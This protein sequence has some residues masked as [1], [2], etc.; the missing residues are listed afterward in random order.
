MARKRLAIPSVDEAKM[1]TNVSNE[2]IF[3]YEKLFSAVATATLSNGKDNPLWSDPVE[4][5]AMRELGFTA[6]YAAGPS[7]TINER[8]SKRHPVSDLNIPRDPVAIMQT[9]LR[10]CYDNP[11]VAKALRVKT[12][13]VI[14]NFSH[15]TNNQT[16]KDFYDKE[17][18]RLDLFTRSREIC[19]MA[20]GVG[21]VPIYWGGEETGRI[22]FVEILDPRLVKIQRVM[23]KY[24][25]YLK[26]DQ[27][28]IDAAR[29]PQGKINIENK[30]RWESMP[31]YW[32]TAILEHI[33][34]GRAGQSYIELKDGSYTVLQNRYCPVNRIANSIDGIPLQP[35]FD[36]LQRYRLLA[37]G[38][39]A[40]AWNVKNMITLI[41]EGDPKLDV[42]S[43]A[44]ADNS[45]LAALQAKF[46]QPDYQLTVYCDPTTEIRYVVPPIEVF[47]PKKYQQVEKE[48]KELLNLPAFMWMDSQSGSYSA[49]SAEL[50]LLREEVDAM[51]MTLRVQFYMPLYSRLRQAAS[52][53]GFAEKAIELPSF[54][55]NSLRD[56]QI[57]LPALGDLYTRGG[58]SLSSYCEAHGL[59]FDYEMKKLEE[60]H[61]QLKSNVSQ[62]INPTI[63]QPLHEPNQGNTDPNR[64]KGGNSGSKSPSPRSPRSKGE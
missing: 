53:P 9:A 38:D 7:V 43:Y 45:R 50:K 61:K 21:I 18:F 55:N 52:K 36:A 15:K 6:P 39:F 49:A 2:E 13:F 51:R 25:L 5:A 63:A 46:Q 28:M 29:D 31:K 20:F 4:L 17:A 59:D 23:G 33:N 19:W 35:A 8:F 24:K 37:A 10:Y 60:E 22:D 3:L 32:R 14:K 42:K 26:I 27:S 47:D 1:T 56:D 41:S 57:W 62:R 16:V 34:T 12:D 48:L 40:V 64:D 30:A 54:D 58:C 44:P 11:F